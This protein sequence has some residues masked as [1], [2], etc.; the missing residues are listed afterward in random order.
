VAAVAP[1]ATSAM[2]D[3]VWPESMLIGADSGDNEKM[4]RQRRRG[5]VKRV[6]CCG[7]RT[8]SGPICRPGRL[9]GTNH[10]AP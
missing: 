10:D 4:A 6:R 7:H 1:A 3:N 2:D 9:S 5:G 8:E